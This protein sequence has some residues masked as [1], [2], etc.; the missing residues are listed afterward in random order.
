MLTEYGL[1][2]SSGGLHLANAES[3]VTLT[4]KKISHVRI[5]LR[6][7]ARGWL[8]R[9]YLTARDQQRY[10]HKQYSGVACE[11]QSKVLFVSI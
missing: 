11:I 6:T 5:S 4:E 10:E 9:R 2:P 7:G 3:L 1:R 8:F